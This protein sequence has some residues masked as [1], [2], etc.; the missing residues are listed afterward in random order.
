MMLLICT[1]NGFIV[2]LVVQEQFKTA[3]CRYYLHNVFVTTYSEKNNP[4]NGLAAEFVNN[5][6]FIHDDLIQ[7]SIYL[8]V[9]YLLG[10]HD[11]YEN[12]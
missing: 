9:Y 11:G 2:V 7:F 5:L 3:H 12:L 1:M 4:C 8:G 6:Y 10:I